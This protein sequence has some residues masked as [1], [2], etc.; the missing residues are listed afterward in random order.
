MARHKRK[1]T[2]RQRR[3][4][5]LILFI[6]E[7]LVLVILLGGLYVTSKLNLIDKTQ[8]DNAKVEKGEID[9]LTKEKLTGYTDIALFGLDNRSEGDYDTGNS[10]V[11]MILS[12]NNDTKEIRMV[13]VYRDTFLDVSSKE[14]ST[15]FQKANSAYARGGPERAISML[16]KNLDLDIDNYVAFDFAA[17]AK[18]IDL[19]G[20]VEVEIEESELEYINAYI[21][22]TGDIIGQ[23]SEHIQ[24]TGTHTLDGV[25]AVAYARIR[26]TGGGDFRRAERQ[27]VVF[28]QM[29]QKVKSADLKTLNALITEIFP[30]IKTDM[31]TGTMITMASSVLGYDM[32]ESQG[33][34][35]ERTTWKTNKKGDCVIPCDLI[36]NVEELHALLY[37][38]EEYT[39]SEKVKKYSDMIINET[40]KTRD[41]A[42]LDEYSL[43]DGS[44]DDQEDTD[45]TE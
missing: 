15:N 8:L 37:G 22:H 32:S 42:V 7:I 18:A 27:R 44:E 41:S 38:S 30:E 40:G 21:D 16:N 36:T 39:P 26:Y 19:L 1:R 2:S 6:V 14:E 3:K 17:V 10:D 29:F 24:T 31:S 28:S 9:D 11:I 43:D 13:S 4:R 25:Q 5:K 33:F 12:I 34:P 23:T 35:F 45:T 20:G